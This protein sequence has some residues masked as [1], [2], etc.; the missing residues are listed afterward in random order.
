MPKENARAVPPPQYLLLSTSPSVLPL[1]SCLW[2]FLDVGNWCRSSSTLKT[3]KE[4]I[5]WLHGC[6]RQWVYIPPLKGIFLG[7]FTYL[8]DLLKSLIVL[9]KPIVSSSW[10][11]NFGRGHLFFAAVLFF[12]LV[13]PFF[14]PDVFTSVI[15]AFEASTCW[16][17]VH[18]ASC[19]TV[20]TIDALLI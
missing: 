17:W 3:C 20:H 9:K 14:I 15:L 7:P 11:G 12:S 4:G 16:G 18:R 5:Q 13:R 19:M 8:E 6:L 2:L 10:G 1:Q